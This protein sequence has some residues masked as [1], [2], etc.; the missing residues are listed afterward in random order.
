MDRDSVIQT[1]RAA[2]PELRRKFHITKLSLFGSFARGDNQPESDVDILVAFEPDST[3]TLLTLG[4]LLNELE[5]ILGR[6]VDVVE[7][8]PRLR[9]EFRRRIE[10]ERRHVA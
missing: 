10:G 4:A 5:S 3:V 8:G 6:R 1:L 7:D 9:P 2:M